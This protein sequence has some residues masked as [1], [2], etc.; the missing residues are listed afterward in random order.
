MTKTLACLVVSLVLLSSAAFAQPERVVIAKFVG[1]KE[2]T[3]GAC[4]SSDREL[5]AHFHA[6]RYLSQ[7]RGGQKKN[8]EFIKCT[9]WQENPYAHMTLAWQEKLI[10]TWLLVLDERSGVLIEKR[11][12]ELLQDATGHLAVCPPSKDPWFASLGLSTTHMNFGNRYVAKVR[13]EADRRFFESDE[14]YVVDGDQ[15]RRSKGVY[16]KSIEAVLRNPDRVESAP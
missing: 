11:S 13:G 12:Y 4:G 2:S 9:H 14:C 16:I 8:I 3:T 1:L 10:P 5:V 7:G 15:A 6:D